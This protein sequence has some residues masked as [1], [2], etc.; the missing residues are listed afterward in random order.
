MANTDDGLNPREAV[1]ELAVELLD[2][3][4][5]DRDLDRELR[6]ISTRLLAIADGVDNGGNR[7]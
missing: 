7:A 2:L 3:V 4:E 6:D 1:W 5:S